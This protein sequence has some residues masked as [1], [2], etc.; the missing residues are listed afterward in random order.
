[1]KD[2]EDVITHGLTDFITSRLGKHVEKA[3]EQ[4]DAVNPDVEHPNV[5]AFVK[6]NRAATHRMAI[7]TGEYFS[8]CRFFLA[9]AP[10]ASFCLSLRGTC[11][12]SVFEV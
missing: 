4:L 10:A 2:L 11:P 6:Q 1:M 7:G 5:L 3:V 9:F 8:R 12:E